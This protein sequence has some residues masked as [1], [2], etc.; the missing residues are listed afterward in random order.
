MTERRS[1]IAAC[2]S[3]ISC[4]VL[5]YT[6][7]FAADASSSYGIAAK[8]PVFGGACPVCIWGPI[9]EAVKEAMKPYGYDVQI[10]YNCN[11]TDSPRFVAK[12]LIPHDLSLSEKAGGDPPPPKAPVDFGVTN[13]HVLW[14]AYDGLYDYK[15]D[16]P[17][18]Q[19]RLIAFLGDPHYFLAA[20][21]ADSG[22]TDLR[23]IK[24]QHLPVRVL[25]DQNAMGKAVLEY[26]GLTKEALESWGG[27]LVPPNAA[28]RKN[29]DVI[30]SD[31]ASLTNNAENN[32]FYEVSQQYSLRYLELALQL[33]EQLAEQFKLDLVDVPLELLRGVDRRIPTVARNGQAIY[34]RA[35]APDDFAYVVAKSIDEHQ[36]L[37]E[38]LNRPYFYDTHQVWKTVGDVPLH[39][40][41]QRYYKEVGYLK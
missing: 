10:C 7:A 8:R 25:A 21:K 15:A 12:A 9:G 27:K 6:A 32:L 20:V 36:R 14:F 19:L 26:Y 23:Q 11:R 40:G 5:A 39:P 3:V 30:I 33:R 24:E 4:A 28:G 13:A 1:M 16:G 2:M 18:H 41:A 29:F 31:H 37:L 38:Y 17:Q 34:A 35:D 22:I